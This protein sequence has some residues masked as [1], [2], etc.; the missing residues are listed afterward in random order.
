LPT[1]PA[2]PERRHYIGIQADFD[3]FFRDFLRASSW[4]TATASND[5]FRCVNPRKIARLR[6]L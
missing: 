1:I 2:R 3:S 4:A 6:S 5:L